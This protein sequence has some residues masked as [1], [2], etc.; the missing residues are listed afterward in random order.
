METNNVIGELERLK[1]TIDQTKEDLAKSEGRLQSV[2][3]RLATEFDL[4][5]L[6]E[7][8][9][10]LVGL[11]SEIDDLDKKIEKEYVELKKEYDW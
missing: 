5:S 6:E 1:N 11:K 8:E 3:E 9:K 2:M 7:V 10:K 4:H